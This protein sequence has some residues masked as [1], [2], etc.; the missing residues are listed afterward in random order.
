[1]PGDMLNTN[2]LSETRPQRRNPRGTR[3][4]LPP[5]L[6]SDVADLRQHLFVLV[7]PSSAGAVVVAT[8]DQR[9]ALSARVIGI[10]VVAA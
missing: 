4:P 8:F 6:F 3:R 5:L 10:P 7:P 1:M 2:I 9:M